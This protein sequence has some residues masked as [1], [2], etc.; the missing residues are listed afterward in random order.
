M[1]SIIAVLNI[2]IYAVFGAL[3]V[4]LRKAKAN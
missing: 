2:P 4:G 3:V 1:Y